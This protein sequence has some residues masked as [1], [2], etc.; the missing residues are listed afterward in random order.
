MGEQVLRE[1][2]NGTESW[3]L[4]AMRRT[5]IAA[6]SPA[7]PALN[8]RRSTPGDDAE[9]HVERGMDLQWNSDLF[10]LNMGGLEFLLSILSECP[11]SHLFVSYTSLSIP[12]HPSHLRCLC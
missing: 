4:Q 9:P 7:M 10:L 5:V 11:A 8:P 2:D 1:S 12:T 3:A 6:A